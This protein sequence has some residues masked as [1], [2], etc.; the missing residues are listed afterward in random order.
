MKLLRRKKEEKWTGDENGNRMDD[1]L[2]LWK[3]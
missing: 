2:P 1:S 3:C